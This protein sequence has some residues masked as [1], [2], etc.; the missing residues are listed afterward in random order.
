[1]I[2]QEYEI[3][4]ELRIY[5]SY[6]ACLETWANT[7]KQKGDRFS[8]RDLAKLIVLFLFICVEWMDKIKRDKFYTYVNSTYWIKTDELLS[9]WD[10]CKLESYFIHLT[11]ICT[12]LFSKLIYNKVLALFYTFVMTWRQAS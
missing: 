5:W 12:R 7:N 4:V 11:I 9:N 6:A 3:I 10:D 1:M 2:A 8:N